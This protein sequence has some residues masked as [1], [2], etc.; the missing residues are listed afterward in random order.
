MILHT[1]KPLGGV[2]RRGTEP[3]SQ[4]EPARALPESFG[5]IG[6]LGKALRL[7]LIFRLSLMAGEGFHHRLSDEPA[8]V[9]VSFRRMLIEILH[10]YI[11]D[12]SY[13]Y[14]P[15]P[16]KVRSDRIKYARNIAPA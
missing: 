6:S 14:A 1:L 15:I 7:H 2:S 16:A 3:K 5:D 12:L 9:Q 8:G 11:C 13:G 4:L 10:S